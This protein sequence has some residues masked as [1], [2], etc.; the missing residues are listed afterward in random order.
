MRL[1]SLLMELDG[2]NCATRESNVT[3][4]SRKSLGLESIGDD[5]G[6]SSWAVQV[7]ITST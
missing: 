5:G 1:L 4:L 7:F 3:S 6:C 2:S